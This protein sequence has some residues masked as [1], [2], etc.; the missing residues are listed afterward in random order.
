MIRE[1]QSINVS[2]K[3]PFKEKIRRLSNDVEDLFVGLYHQP[4]VLPV[5]DDIEPM[6]PR[7]TLNSKNGHSTINFS[8]ISIDF[9]VKFDDNYR[10]NY[11]KCEDYIQERMILV[12]KFLEKAGI[13][14][15]Y[16]IGVTTQIRFIGDSP[17]N[18]VELLKNT[19]LKQFEIDNLYDYNQKITLLENDEYFYNVTIGNYR[20][21]IGEIIN[22]QIPAIV[23]FEKAKVNRKGIFVILDINN[24]FKYTNKGISTKTESLDKVFEKI[25]KDNRE[26]IST[27]VYKY[28]PQNINEEG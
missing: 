17:K 2:L 7:I 16:Y 15:I 14:T 12:H 13:D 10:Y 18:E 5:P 25:Y 8:Q 22:G 11:D 23:S 24:R 27:K 1:I 20:D 6:I 4:T 3:F 26:W 28:L 19:Y 9:V 21:Y